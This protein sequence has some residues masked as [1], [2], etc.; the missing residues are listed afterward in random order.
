M[1]F[2]AALDPR[3]RRLSFLMESQHFELLEVLVSAAESIGCS[4]TSDTNDAGQSVEEVEC[5]G[6]SAWWGKAG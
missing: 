6:S 5:T 3:F 4:T 1:V 2:S